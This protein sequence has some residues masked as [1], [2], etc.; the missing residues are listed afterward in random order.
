MRLINFLA[1]TG[2]LLFAVTAVAAD[3]KS[4]S[5]PT[6][7]ASGVAPATISATLYKP[8]GNGPFPAIIV[9]HGC[10]GP[11]SHTLEW[12]NRLVDWGYVAI[13]PDSFGSRGSGGLC[14][15]T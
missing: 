10:A 1:L 14:T 12:A 9:L 2:A 15:N 11:D 8:D 3:R 5:Y 7:A 13:V 4:V 6:V